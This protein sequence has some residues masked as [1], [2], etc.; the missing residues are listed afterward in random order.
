[1]ALRVLGIALLLLVLAGCRLQGAPGLPPRGEEAPEVTW[2]PTKN[3][4]AD[5]KGFGIRLMPM[6]VSDRYTVLFYS[7]LAPEEFEGWQVVPE[8]VLVEDDIG[9]I[10]RVKVTPLESA[11]G[12]SLGAFSLPPLRSA[13]SR[14]EITVAALKAR[15][16]STG[17]A[18]S[19]EGKWHLS[20]LKNLSPGSTFTGRKQLFNGIWKVEHRGVIIR[21]TFELVEGEGGIAPTPSPEPYAERLVFWVSALEPRFV[22]VEV[23]ADGNVRRLIKE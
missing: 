19:I 22:Q 8:A 10:Y 16:P 4:S 3:L 13:A 11:D 15:N 7:L 12:I 5:S 23:D 18:R 6:I 1:M 17:Q 20:P 21:Y 2:V 9:A 14:L